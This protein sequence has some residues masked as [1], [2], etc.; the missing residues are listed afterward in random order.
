MSLV[1]FGVLAGKW[2]LNAV[3]QKVSGRHVKFYIILG[4]LFALSFQCI[5]SNWLLSCLASNE[6]AHQIVANSS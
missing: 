6:T 3:M 5:D 1:E 2:D 4:R